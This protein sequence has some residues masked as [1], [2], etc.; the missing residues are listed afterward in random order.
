MFAHGTTSKSV[1]GVSAPM[2]SDGGSTE[3]RPCLKTPV[4]PFGRPARTLCA[5]TPTAAGW[6]DGWRHLAR[7]T[8][9]QRGRGGPDTDSPLSSHGCGGLGRRRALPGW[10]EGVGGGCKRPEATRRR[11]SGRRGEERGTKQVESS[12]AADPG[13]VQSD[14]LRVVCVASAPARPF[15]CLSVCRSV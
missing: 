13:H 5:W 4:C 1:R 15:V 12:A 3:G 10:E 14:L 6:M 9:R 11:R 7:R 8:A 2:R